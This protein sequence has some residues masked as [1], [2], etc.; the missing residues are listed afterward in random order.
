M[1]LRTILLIIAI[2]LLAASLIIKGYGMLQLVNKELA[3]EERMARYKKTM[4]VTYL[5]LA[6]VILI[7]LYLVLT[8]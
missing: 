7:V 3:Q 1:E 8:K 4:P 2:V 6:P 5:M